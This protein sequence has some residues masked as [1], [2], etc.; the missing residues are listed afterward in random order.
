MQ[1]RYV[2]VSSCRSEVLGSRSRQGAAP[3]SLT[4]SC[5]LL[6]LLDGLP[7]VHT[8]GPLRKS[9]GC[10]GTWGSPG[11][12]AVSCSPQ[13]RQRGDSGPAPLLHW[14]VPGALHSAVWALLSAPGEQNNVTVP[15][16]RTKIFR[17]G[18]PPPGLKS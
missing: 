11:R 1:G 16:P 18:N 4:F 8:L 3:L 17:P 15:S 6:R 2:C 10:S 7:H 5:F 12:P 14:Y 13:N 9:Q